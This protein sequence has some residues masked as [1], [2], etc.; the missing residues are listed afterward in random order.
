MAASNPLLDI[1]FLKKLYSYHHREIF[2]R[3]TALTFEE[4]P[5]ECIEGRITGGSVNVDGTSSMR[6]SCSLT[7]VANDVNIREYY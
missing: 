3:V 1:E 6:R 2:A 7:M 5:V 4:R